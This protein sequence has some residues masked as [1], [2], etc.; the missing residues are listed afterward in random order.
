MFNEFNFLYVPVS[1][2][3]YFIQMNQK[4]NVS[5]LLQMVHRKYP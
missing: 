2:N 3:P 5:D 1:Y 4:L